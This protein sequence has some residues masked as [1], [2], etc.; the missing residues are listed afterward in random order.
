MTDLLR[1]AFSAE[2][3]RKLADPRTL[4]RGA[5][6]FQDRRVELGPVGPD[7]VEATVRGT[8]PYWVELRVSGG[9]P[10]WSC[11]C[12]VGAEGQFCKHAVAVAMAVDPAV[13]EGGLLFR[14]AP[15]RG[16]ADDEGLRSYLASLGTE[17]LVDLLLEQAAADF[18]LR[19]RLTARAAA[20]AGAGIDEG[21][22]RKRITAAFRTPGG[23]VPYRRAADWAAGVSDLIDGLADLLDAGH[24][25]AVVRLAERAH[26]RA[27]RAI[28]AVDDSDGCLNDISFRLA[29]L[30]L[31]ACWECRPDPVQLARRLVDLEMTTDLLGFHRAAAD[32]AEVLGPDGLAEYRRVVEA[33]WQALA[34]DSGEWSSE[35]FALRQTRI[36]LALAVGDPDELIA[37]K[38]DDMKAPSDYQEIAEALQRA[39]RV[40]EAIDWARHGL[41][42]FGR[43][44]WQT[45]PLRDLCAAL[46]RGRGEEES[47]VRLYWQAFAEAPSLGAYR[48]LLAEAG[49]GSAHLEQRALTLLRTRVTGLPA[50]PTPQTG[51]VASPLVEILLYEGEVEEAWDTAVACGCEARLWLPLARAREATY[52]LDAVAVYEREALAQIDTKKND[53][54]RNAVK[55]LAAIR[56][57]ADA[58]GDPEVFTRTLARVRTEHRPKRNLMALLDAEGW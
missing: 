54:Y 48:Q 26:Q 25:E 17:Q 3:L 19:D 57:L 9:R 47:A 32:Y 15:E 46:L 36:G 42:A 37:V 50:G 52:P 33:R 23:F 31:R 55:H 45:G 8:M 49:D 16:A 28:G 7:A 2:G 35:R 22:W 1:E 20:A 10:A 56:R 51:A 58:A 30:H 21:A 4:M 24:A 34:P 41:E 14:R 12:P 29:A 39:G 40:E 5:S 38:R 11:T 13:G 53:G 6:Y 18:R 43:R 44:H 27:D